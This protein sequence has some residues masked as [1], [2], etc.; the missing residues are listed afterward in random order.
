MPAAGGMRC[1][2][3]SIIICIISMCW[4][5]DQGAGRNE[6]RG[7]GN[8]SGEGHDGLRC[9]LKNALKG[10]ALGGTGQGFTCAG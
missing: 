1:A 10:A 9:G 4:A 7:K 3:M 6:C 2:I 5:I 8:D